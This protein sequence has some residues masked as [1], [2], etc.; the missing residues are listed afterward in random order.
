MRQAGLLALGSWRPADRLPGAWLQWRNCPRAW[1]IT[2][3]AP[4]R[5]CTGFPLG[6]APGRGRGPVVRMSIAETAADATARRALPER[7]P[8]RVERERLARRRLGPGDQLAER[9]VGRQEVVGQV[10]VLGRV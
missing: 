10:V 1:P 7:S 8:R 9:R 4:R 6:R 2:A 3:A 5:T